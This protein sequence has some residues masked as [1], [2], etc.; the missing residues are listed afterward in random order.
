MKTYLLKKTNT[1][2]PFLLKSNIQTRRSIFFLKEYCMSSCL[3][4]LII[5]K[6]QT[7]K[8]EKIVKLLVNYDSF[9]LFFL[10]LG[11][12]NVANP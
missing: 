4:M 9:I 11:K 6:F 1:I 7:F 8:N 3:E 2:M 10:S 5:F 12:L